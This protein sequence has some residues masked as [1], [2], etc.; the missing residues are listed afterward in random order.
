MEIE[1]VVVGDGGK[2]EGL[3]VVAKWLSGGDGTRGWWG[4]EKR[5]IVVWG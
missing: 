5:D 1:V 4:G 2:G 3:M